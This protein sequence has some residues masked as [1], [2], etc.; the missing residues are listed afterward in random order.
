MQLTS[1]DN[2]GPLIAKF[3]GLD[4][5]KVYSLE[6]VQNLSSSGFI[7]KQGPGW[8]P[9]LKLTG[10]HFAHIGVQLPVM[11]PESGLLFH[12]QAL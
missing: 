9:A 6:I 11:R 2:F 4:K 7:Q 3:D 12:F 5:E 10:D 1:L 8:W